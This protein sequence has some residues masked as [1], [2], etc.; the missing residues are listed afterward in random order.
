M[1]LRPVFHALLPGVLALLTVACKEPPG[2]ELIEEGIYL[3]PGHNGVIFEQP[4]I[5]NIGFIVGDTCIAVIDTGGS[6]KEGQALSAAVKKISRKPVCYVI[7]TH[8]HPDH[9][10]GNLAFKGE[11]VQF[12]GHRNLPR[13]MALLGPTYVQRAARELDQQ[14]TNEWL[15][16]PDRQVSE[17][18]ELDLGGRR[19]LLT[20]HAQAHTDNDLSVYDEKTRTLWAGD[21][22]FV[23]HIP[24]L[25]GSGSVNGWLKVIAA[26]RHN[27]AGTIVPGHGPVLHDISHA[28]DAER[29]YLGVLQDETRAWLARDGEIDTALEN[30]GY[31][32]Q[33][34]WE[35]FDHYHKRNVSYTYTEL[36]WED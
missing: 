10:L 34:K 19:L 21:L 36:E 5:A 13:A 6:L 35:M 16:A 9:I 1:R 3:L 8:V 32:E 29:R 26:L 20:A 7:N 24:V 17:T 11:G 28:L 4:G 30:I 12:I 15:V 23:E 25:G 18:L 2:I 33:G 14:A 22:L 31:S 27:D